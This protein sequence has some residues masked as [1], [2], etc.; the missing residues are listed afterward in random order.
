MS[1]NKEGVR[2]RVVNSILNGIISG[3][4]RSGDKLPSLDELT[5]LYNIGRTTAQ[6]ACRELCEL[7]YCKSVVGSGYYIRKL[8]TS[9]LEARKRNELTKRIKDVVSECLE[10]GMTEYEISQIVAEEVM[11][12]SEE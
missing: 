3:V 10:I 7:G 11:L 12:R 5:K 1:E 2:E 8:D 4:Y 9:A 6:N